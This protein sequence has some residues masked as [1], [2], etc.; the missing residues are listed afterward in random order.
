VGCDDD[1]GCQVKEAA[2]VWGED[3][4]RIYFFLFVFITC[5]D[6]LLGRQVGPWS[7]LSLL[8]AAGMPCHPNRW[9]PHVRTAVN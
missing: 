8:M 7:H 6:F 1:L 2:V 5:F 9:V 3:D 4:L